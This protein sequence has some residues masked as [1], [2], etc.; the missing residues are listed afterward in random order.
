MQTPL[1]V[2]RCKLDLLLQEDLSGR[3]YGLV[4]ELYDLNTRMGHLNRNLLL[5]AKIEN[6]QYAAKE[7][8]SLRNFIGSLIPSCWNVF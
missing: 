6:E 5:L 1:A 7:R 2:T 4:S 3:Q 8:I